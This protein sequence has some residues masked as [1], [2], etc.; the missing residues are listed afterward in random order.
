MARRIYTTVENNSLSQK[1]HLRGQK[2]NFRAYGYPEKVV[3]IEIQI[4]LKISQTELRKP[5][6]IE[7]S[8]YLTFTSTFNPNNAKKYFIS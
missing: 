4:V 2:G 1:K 5:K 6:T 3:E 8:N 7:N